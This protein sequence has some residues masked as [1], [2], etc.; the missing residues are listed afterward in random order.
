MSAHV[1]QLPVLPLLFRRRHF[2]RDDDPV[3][4]RHR[5]S[6]KEWVLADLVDLDIGQVRCIA[7]FK[8]MPNAADWYRLGLG[9][10]DP[11][12]R[13]AQPNRRTDL[14]AA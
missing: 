6:D 5:G 10:T 13:A 11:S 1:R 3:R 2:H 7:V 8:D 4:S 9:P 12:R 14:E